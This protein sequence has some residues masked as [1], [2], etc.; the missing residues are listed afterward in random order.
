MRRIWVL[1]IISLLLASGV[2]VY[3]A[4]RPKVSG[5]CAPLAIDYP[6]AGTVFPPDIVAPAFRWKGAVAD[7]RTWQV[8]V[9]FTDG[10]PALQATA[11]SSPWTPTESYWETIKSRS[12]D[13]DAT[14]TVAGLRADGSAACRGSVS[15]RTAKEPVDAPIFYREVPLPFSEAVKNPSRIRWRFGPVSSATQPRVVLSNLPVCGNCHSFT[16]DGRQMGMDVDYANDKGSY[17]LSAVEPKTVLTPS[18]IITWSDYRR[19]DKTPTFGLMSQI[20]PDGRYAVSTVKDH[21]VFVPKPD[22]AFSQLFFPIRGI[23]AVY[24]RQAKR[25]FA[26]PGADDPKYVQSNPTW[27]P[28]GRYLVFARAPA[29]QLRQTTDHDAVLLTPEQCAEFLKEGKTFR[30]DLYRVEFN[31]GKGG[32]AEPLTGASGNGMSNYF[33]KYSPDGRWIVFCK[34][35][36]FMLLQP[37]SELWIISAAGG[38]AR[39]LECNTRR[40]N[41]WH[42]WSP[43][44]HWL[45]FTSKVNGPYSQIFLTHID[46]TGHASPPVELANFTAADRAAN[47][48]EFVNA[49]PGALNTIV[50]QF[51]D[52]HSHWRA[53][54]EYARAKDWANAERMYRKALE[55]N[56]K[57]AEA[58]YSLAVML[59]ARG[60][61]DEAIAH[62]QKAIEIKPDFAEAHNNLGLALAG[63]GHVDDALVHYQKAV[64]IEPKNV[65]AQVNYAD[66]LAGRGMIAEAI[67]HY[68]NA[69]AIDADDVVAHNNLGLALAGQGQVDEAVAQYR[70]ALEINP[71]YALAHNNLAM[72]LASRG[73]IDEAITHYQK[74]LELKP[75]YAE[76]HNNLG[77][78]L[79]AGRGQVDAAIAHF[80][81]AL[82]IKPDYIGARQN[83]ERAQSKQ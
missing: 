67:A 64:E 27:S 3:F 32:P 57:S 81:K 21:S 47:I 2:A 60:K 26:L 31:G 59:V 50:D 83:L 63:S 54:N 36:S 78:V 82:E 46:D 72:S 62:Y 35:A 77:V 53:G 16:A 43:N 42:T 13:R 22:L 11:G 34:A 25:F 33:A 51:I 76:A 58:H 5:S 28:D 75:D 6:A 44:S 71:D 30:F 19:E 14:V 12:A 37:D 39:R 73:Q 66:A 15:I 69:L 8:E 18:K 48:P 49:P 70:K 10:E 52:D 80:K 7:V 56:A 1:S 9:D 79:V 17:I 41:S 65:R 38:Q 55:I 24:D 61:L 29:Y 74:A 40:M 20:S 23:L 4:C 45:A 68:R